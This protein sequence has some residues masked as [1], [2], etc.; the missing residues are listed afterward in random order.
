MVPGMGLDSADNDLSNK[1]KSKV[2][3]MENLFE[4]LFQKQIKIEQIYLY[5]DLVDEKFITSI[6]A[7]MSIDVSKLDPLQNVEKSEK[8]I[9]TLPALGDAS[10]FVESVGVVLDQ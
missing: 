10:K 3:Q 2:K 8:L 7:N 1:I 6:Q 9:T 5:G 4:Q